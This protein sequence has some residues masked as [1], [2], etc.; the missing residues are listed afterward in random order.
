MRDPYRS[1]VGDFLL[2]SY[3]QIAARLENTP[4]F[5]LLYTPETL[6]PRTK[7]EECT[8]RSV[9]KILSEQFTQTLQNSCVAFS[10][11]QLYMVSDFE[12]CQYIASFAAQFNNQT[13]L[14]RDLFW[15]VVDIESGDGR[16]Y[17]YGT[18]TTKKRIIAS[19]TKEDFACI[20]I[21]KI[22]FLDG[23]IPFV[24]QVCS[25][26]YAYTKT[27]PTQATSHITKMITR[28]LTTKTKEFSFPLAKGTFEVTTDRTYQH[29]YN[30]T[31]ISE[32]TKAEICVDW[33]G[34]ALSHKTI[35][36][37]VSFYEKLLP[38]ASSEED[39]VNKLAESYR[40]RLAVANVFSVKNKRRVFQMYRKAEKLREY[41][42]EDAQTILSSFGAL[43][44][45]V[46]F[47]ELLVR[48]VVENP[49]IG[50][51]SALSSLMLV[52]E[53]QGDHNADN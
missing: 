8:P 24:P 9:E 44:P 31:I 14:G 36:L 47:S 52:S 28:L 45:K 37:D 20:R 21:S 41:R 6:A 33:E 29:R 13:V 38:F 22:S 50:K 1:V 43:D 34:E 26:R 18:S 3:K 16:H 30:T 35:R 7:R 46:S 25:A 5:I 49:E 11:A 19:P 53:I 27:L 40:V 51:A 32:V 39:F 12:E 15:L 2:N 48:M 42:R 10:S 4:S 23:F 17:I